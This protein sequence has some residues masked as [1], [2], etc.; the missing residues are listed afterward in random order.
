VG[1]TSSSYA[2]L[3]RAAEIIGDLEAKDRATK[4]QME[5]ENGSLRRAAISQQACAG[6]TLCPES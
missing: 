2:L 1:E 5:S 3:P 6:C 4:S